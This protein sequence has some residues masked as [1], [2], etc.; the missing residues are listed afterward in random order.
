VILPATPEDIEEFM[1][2]NKEIKEEE[3]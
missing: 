2:K 1:R 3:I